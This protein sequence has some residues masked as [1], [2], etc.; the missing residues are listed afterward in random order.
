LT[1][2]GTAVGSAKLVEKILGPTAD[3]IGS[4]LRDWTAHKIDN[5]GRIFAFAS[6]KPGDRISEPGA[7][8]PKV[9]KG[10]L[11][12]GAFC[13]DELEAEYFGGVLASS[14]SEVGRDDRGAALLSLVSRLTTHQVRAHFLFYTIVKSLYGGVDAN[15]NL[16]EGRMKLNTFL[17]VSTYHQALEFSDRE[18]YDA[19]L[20]HVMFGLAREVLIEQSFMYGSPEILR[21]AYPK[22][23]QHGILFSPSPLGVELYLWA[24][25]RGHLGVHDF[26]KPEHRL[27]SRSK[28]TIG[29]GIRSINLP[30]RQLENLES[31]PPPA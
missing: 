5:V 8:P 14:R 25:G 13:D 10:I 30:E 1:I 20:S 18:N 6:E 15:I 4:G 27:V 23:D 16:G 21:N 17:P 12:D 31:P 19:I 9:L 22:V 29:P 7:V 2:L 11:E 24:H 28:L 26:L 3:Y